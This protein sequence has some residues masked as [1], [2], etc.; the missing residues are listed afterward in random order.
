MDV[1]FYD[2]R[3][4]REVKAS[5]LFPIN[6]IQKIVVAD[7]DERKW[8]SDLDELSVIEKKLGEIGYKS[9]NCESYQNW[10]MWL[11]ESE[12]VFLRLEG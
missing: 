7:T 10:D 4:K 5:Q 8:V 9:D 11:M 1:I 2:R 3:N 6:F 12:L